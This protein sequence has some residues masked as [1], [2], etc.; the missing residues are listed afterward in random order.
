MS[1]R[2][3]TAVMKS[4]VEKAVAWAQRSMRTAYHV[5]VVP[6]TRQNLVESDEDI[7]LA[8]DRT[9]RGIDDKDHFIVYFN[10][11]H[12]EKASV[13]SL[14]RFAGHEVIHMVLF[15]FGEIAQRGVRSEVEQ[16]ELMS[17]LES[18]TYKFQRILFG[19]AE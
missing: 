10:P 12:V 13:Q 5:P 6:M 17:E 18:V 19:E 3:K 16:R 4:R 9:G 7:V 8:C 14:R 11:A 1:S 2:G 15:G